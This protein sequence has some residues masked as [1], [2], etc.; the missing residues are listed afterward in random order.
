MNKEDIRRADDIIGHN[1][2]GT[3]SRQIKE[4]KEEVDERYIEDER[5]NTEEDREALDEYKTP[6]PNDWIEEKIDGVKMAI[7]HILQK[8]IADKVWYLDKGCEI[9]LKNGLD[10]SEKEIAKYFTQQKEAIER[11]WREKIKNVKYDY[12]KSENQKEHERNIDIIKR[13][14]NQIKN[15]LLQ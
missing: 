14:V 1:V 15:Q 8:E 7:H 10:N 4:E 3:E 6:T 5:G 12:P 13:T 9:Q 11:E 2:S